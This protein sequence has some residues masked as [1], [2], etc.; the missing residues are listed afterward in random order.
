MKLLYVTLA[1][2]CTG[3]LSDEVEL[4]DNVHVLTDAN[5]K[6]FLGSNEFVFVK[7]YAPWCGHCKKMAP[8]YAKL[9]KRMLDENSNIKIAKLDATVHKEAATEHKVQ[10][11]PT[12]KFFIN[13]SP[14]DY[15]G[16]REEDA[17]YNWI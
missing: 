6:D 9:G 16:A 14:V 13:G 7:F 15:Q 5:F 8:G 10:G 12:L 1:V 2:L 17:I 11:F 3:V 4:D